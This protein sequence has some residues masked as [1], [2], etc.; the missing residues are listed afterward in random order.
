MRLRNGAPLLVEKSLGDGRVMAFLSTTSDEWNNWFNNNETASFFGFVME[1]VPYLSHRFGTSKALLVGEPKTVAFPASGFE[2]EVRFSGPGGDD[3]ADKITAAPAANSTGSP[4]PAPPGGYPPGAPATVAKGEPSAK[5]VLQTVTYV[6]TETAGFYKAEL[7]QSSQKPEI[8]NFSVNVDPGEGDLRALTGPDLASRLAPVNYKFQK[9]ADYQSEVDQTR[10]RNLGDLLLLILLIVL[11]LEQLFAWSCG[12]HV[13]SR[14]TN[15]WGAGT[16][17]P[18]AGRGQSRPAGNLSYG[19]G[20]EAGQ[21]ENL[22]YPGAK[23][24]ST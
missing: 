12:Y 17:H 22:S 7:T 11:V 24:G 20:S 23:G 5:D 10:G 9:A 1:M 3:S 21:V 4:R 15:P 8:R 6:K 19:S 2:P 14:M 16:G 13:S 18:L